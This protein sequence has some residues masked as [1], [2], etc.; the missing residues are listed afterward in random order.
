MSNGHANCILG[1]CCPPGSAQQKQALVGE[2]IGKVPTINREH[3]DV[4]ATWLLENFDLAPVGTLQPLK[5]A[6][7]K[8]ARENL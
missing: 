8:L 7:A 5:D 3:A 6:I 2:I 1:V 4:I